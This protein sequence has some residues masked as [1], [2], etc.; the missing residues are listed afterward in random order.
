MKLGG[1]M[2]SEMSD[3]SRQILNDI[4]YMGNLKNNQTNT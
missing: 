1:I 4:T 2:L 3:R